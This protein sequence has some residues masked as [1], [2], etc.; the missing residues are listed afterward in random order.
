MT[1]I[2]GED[3]I[4]ASVPIITCTECGRN[5]DE[6]IHG[7]DSLRPGDPCDS[8]DCPSHDCPCCR[9]PW[10]GSSVAAE[11]MACYFQCTTDGITG[12]RS[13]AKGTPAGAK[14]EAALSHD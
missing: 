14:K 8:D 6:R 1:L 5:C 2:R 10:R 11:C 12:A 3:G 4:P 9:A 7:S 13:C